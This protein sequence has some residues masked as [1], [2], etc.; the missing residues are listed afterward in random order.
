VTRQNEDIAPE[1]TLDPNDWEAMRKL[2]HKMLDDMLDYMKTI[3]E[4]PVWQHV[5]NRIKVQFSR[6]VPQYPQ[7]PEE[8]YEEFVEKVLY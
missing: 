7:P 8:I 6:P 3:R 5:P 4:R 2:G 1:E